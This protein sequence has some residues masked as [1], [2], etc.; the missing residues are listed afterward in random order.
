M[1]KN[2]V[3]FA[4]VLVYKPQHI[5]FIFY[6]K[7]MILSIYYSQI[8][9][10]SS[11]WWLITEYDISPMFNPSNTTGAIRGVGTTYLSRTTEFPSSF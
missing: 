11:R 9:P 6:D 1:K 4:F 2:S 8:S 5:N 7:E 10:I 3:N